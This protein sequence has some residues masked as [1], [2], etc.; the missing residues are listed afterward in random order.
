LTESERG[1]FTTTVTN[2]P[3]PASEHQ[4]ALDAEIR[5][6]QELELLTVRVQGKAR[7]QRRAKR[8]WTPSD[9]EQAILNLP[10]KL[11]VEAYCQALDTAGVPFPTKWQKKGWPRFYREAWESKDE[12]LCDNIKNDRTNVWNRLKK[13]LA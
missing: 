3:K 13:R 7:A 4:A 9:R 11:T 5:R 8:P 12:R 6:Q 1:I 2:K 10:R